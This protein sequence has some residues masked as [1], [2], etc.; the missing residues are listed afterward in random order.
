MVSKNGLKKL[1]ISCK[2]NLSFN[3]SI[4]YALLHGANNQD[5]IQTYTLK[6]IESINFQCSGMLENNQKFNSSQ[7]TLPM[8]FDFKNVW[9]DCNFYLKNQKPMFQGIEKLGADKKIFKFQNQNGNRTLI[10]TK[11]YKFEVMF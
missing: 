3:N 1:N 11:S 7:I 4:E 2:T 10:E 8:T 6:E 9:Q 5:K